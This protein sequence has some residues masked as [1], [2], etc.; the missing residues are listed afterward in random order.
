M[1]FDG[2]IRKIIYVKK[3]GFKI[4]YSYFFVGSINDED[5]NL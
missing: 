5:S 1:D 4:D 2:E 3:C